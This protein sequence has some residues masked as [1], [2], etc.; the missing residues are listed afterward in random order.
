[1]SKNK[2]TEKF[3]FNLHNFDEDGIDGDT[4][5]AEDTVV[6]DLP[7]P[8][9]VFSEDELESAKAQAYQDGYKKGQEDTRANQQQLIQVA[10]QTLVADIQALLNA[11]EQRERRFEAEAVYLASHIFEKLFPIY[12]RTHGFPEMQAAIANAIQTHHPSPRDRIE[13]LTAP[14]DL[15]LMRDYFS[16]FGQGVS[17]NIEAF[18]ALASGQCEIRWP[19]GGF[20]YDG[21]TLASSIAAALANNLDYAGYVPREAGDINEVSSDVLTE[22]CDTMQ[23]NGAD[24]ASPEIVEDASFAPEEA[25]FVSGTVEDAPQDGGDKTEIDGDH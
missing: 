24:I 20:S 11:E 25:D 17:V 10:I 5:V 19:D 2:K 4:V 22:E 15:V 8:P 14:D 9:P 13:I 6:E 7:P 21:P 3:F 16:K 1:M 12:S 23:E 18:P